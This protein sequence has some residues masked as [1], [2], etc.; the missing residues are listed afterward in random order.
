VSFSGAAAAR[1][2]GIF[3]RKESGMIEWRFVAKR[4]AQAFALVFVVLAASYVLRGRQPAL[5][6]RD[7]LLWALVTALLFAGVV[8]YNRRHDKPCALCRDAVADE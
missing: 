7:A 8:V 6:A 2:S 1:P 3:Q 4:F 5:A